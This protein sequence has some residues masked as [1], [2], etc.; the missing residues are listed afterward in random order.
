[1]TSTVGERNEPESLPAVGFIGVGEI[2]GAM[3]EGLCVPH[4]V[5]AAIYLSPRGEE[6]S[7][8][9]AD[10]FETVTRCASNQEVADRAQVLV[11]AVL[12]DIVPDVLG[13]LT[14]KP[15]TTLISAVAGVDHDQLAALVGPDV[16]VIRSVP[17]PPVRRRSGVT[18]VFPP[19]PQAT[20][21]FEVLGG[22]LPVHD[23]DQFA[24]LTVAS[25]T[26]ST[27]FAYLAAVA[28]WTRQH[29][30]EQR[31]AE[32]YLRSL[33]ASV[34]G[35]LL[36]EPGTL[37]EVR[38]NHETPGGLNAQLRG[39]WFD[40]IGREALSTELDRILTRITAGERGD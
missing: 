8:A 25:S 33:F 16:T 12:P 28:D 21:L 24:A 1:M 31:A 19:H 36:S 13:D 2:A 9:L 6:R 4:P 10:R 17:M 27:H 26:V 34:G 29:G 30:I 38:S 15:G 11:L 20:A 37:D 23:A 14:L 22:A 35:S 32:E 40:D 39:R 5:V 7:T 3:V 18:A